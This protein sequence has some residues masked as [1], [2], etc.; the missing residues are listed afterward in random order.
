M[1]TS[2]KNRVVLLDYY[3]AQIHKTKK[4]TY[5]GY[6]VRNPLTGSL[7]RKKIKLN[8][9]KPA[10]E[11][12]MYGR[13]LVIELNNKLS[14]GW[15]PFL[16]QEAPRSFSLLSETIEKY[17]TLKTKELREDSIRSYSNI[18]NNFYGWCENY[19]KTSIYI[20]NCK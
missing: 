10:R 17:I 4:C 11:R 9:I 3:P 12:L 8:W 15:N 1:P 20:I 2:K 16:E 5:V 7:V 6:H 18:L 13:R 14:L 19:F